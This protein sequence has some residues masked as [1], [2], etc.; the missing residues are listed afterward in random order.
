MQKAGEES[1]RNYHT[2]ESNPMPWWL[3][4]LWLCFFIFAFVYLYLYLL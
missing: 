1:K 4:L 3:A 2:Y